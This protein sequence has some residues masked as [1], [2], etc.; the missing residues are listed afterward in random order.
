MN[1]L[2]HDTIFGKR[3]TDAI[4][5]R[6]RRCVVFRRQVSQLIPEVKRPESLAR[7][8]YTFPPNHCAA[9]VRTAL[10]APQ[11]KARRVE[12]LERL[13]QRILLKSALRLRTRYQATGNKNA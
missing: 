5:R 7:V 13:R 11:L 8:N 3:C 9:R 10:G 2:Q 4:I 12:E 6:F 1:P